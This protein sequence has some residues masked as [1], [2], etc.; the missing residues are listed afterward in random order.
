M[1]RHEGAPGHGRWNIWDVSS[2]QFWSLTLRMDGAKD[3]A[4]QRRDW[5]HAALKFN[6]SSLEEHDVFW[7]K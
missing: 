4:S 5:T 6:Y 1:Y 3:D 7:N 2:V